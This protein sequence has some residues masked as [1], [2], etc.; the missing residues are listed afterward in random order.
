MVGLEVEEY[1]EAGETIGEVPLGGGEP[2]LA[3]PSSGNVW[4]CRASGCGESWKLEASCGCGG[5][6]GVGGS[7]ER[8]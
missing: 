8:D 1:N 7:E 5:D 2:P 4:K 6:T 3:A